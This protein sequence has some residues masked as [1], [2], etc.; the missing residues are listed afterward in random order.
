MKLRMF[1]YQNPVRTQYKNFRPKFTF[2]GFSQ[3]FVFGKVVPLCVRGHNYF[4]VSALK[5]NYALI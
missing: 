5:A 2:L 1:F 4:I 3:N